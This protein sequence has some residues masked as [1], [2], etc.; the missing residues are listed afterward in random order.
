MVVST[1][2]EGTEMS[3]VF[4]VIAEEQARVKV[5]ETEGRIGSIQLSLARG[6]VFIETFA[7]DAADA[8]AT[9]QTLPMAK[10]WDLDV[11]PLAAPTAPG[12]AS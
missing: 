10:W 4:A 5:L 2:K 1:F 6:T 8:A 12:D 7:N 3:E 11:F 9:V